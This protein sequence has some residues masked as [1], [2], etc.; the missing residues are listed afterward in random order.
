MWYNNSPPASEQRGKQAR[1]RE[2]EP[3]EGL[4]VPFPKFFRDGSSQNVADVHDGLLN[5]AIIVSPLQAGLHGDDDA[6]CE[7]ICQPSASRLACRDVHL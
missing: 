5:G 7:G 4:H 6:S 1:H 2:P 3:D